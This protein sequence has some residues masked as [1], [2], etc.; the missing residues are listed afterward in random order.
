MRAIFPVYQLHLLRNRI[1]PVDLGPALR[2]F[3][4]AAECGTE[5]L[6]SKPLEVAQL[7][8]RLA[9]GHPIRSGACSEEDKIISKP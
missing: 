3:V 2:R 9:I 7:P 1:S 6:I 8:L 5:G 4:R